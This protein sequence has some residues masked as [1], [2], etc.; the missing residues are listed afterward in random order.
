MGT[1]IALIASPIVKIA[2]TIWLGTKAL[3]FAGR[4]LGGGRRGVGGYGASIPFTPSRSFSGSSSD[5]S[6]HDWS[7]A[8]AASSARE[9]DDWMSRRNDFVGD[10]RESFLVDRSLDDN[11]YR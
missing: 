2:L 7:S 11:D 9:H 5:T 10:H 3:S 4:L 8:A 1:L 6:S